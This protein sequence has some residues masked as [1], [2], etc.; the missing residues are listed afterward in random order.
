MWSAGRLAV[1]VE[2]A[3][4]VA[5]AAVLAVSGPDRLRTPTAQ[6]I[7]SAAPASPAPSPTPSPTT[8]RPGPPW[9]TT[10]P[11]TQFSTRGSTVALTFDDGPDPINTPRLLDL[12]ARY[13]VKATFCLVGFRVRE[14]QSLVKRIA[15]EGHTLCNHSWQHLKDLGKRED[16]YLARD[17]EA[18]NEQI[19][20][21]VPDAQVVWFRAPYGNF[22]PRLN[23]FAAQQGM[24]PV[25]WNVD[26]GC[27]E[28]GK[29]GTGDRMIQH[30]IE[31]VQRQ[32]RQGSVILSHDNG[33]PFTVTAY[34]TLIP[35]L[36][37][38]FTLEPL[39]VAA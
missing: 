1:A 34:E 24:Q 14:R 27:T 7:A 8:P 28:T 31:T 29:Y 13:H 32:A 5:A 38:R 18:T 9:P 15:A 10:G 37:E 26:D 3:L 16:Q 19:H 21:A 33:K 12:L 22:S 20:R 30:M 25:G 23:G 17:L 35:W 2:V 11:E 4:I 6:P 39:P 36:K